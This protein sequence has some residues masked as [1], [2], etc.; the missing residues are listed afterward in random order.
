[1]EGNKKEY[2]EGKA[3]AG[4]LGEEGTAIPVR[5]FGTNSLKEGAV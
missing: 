4:Y 2:R 3:T 1:M 5:L